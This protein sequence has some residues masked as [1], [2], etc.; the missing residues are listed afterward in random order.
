MKR[1]DSSRWRKLG[2]L[3]WPLI[4]VVSFFMATT[5]LY[6]LILAGRMAGLQLPVQGVTASLA[7]SVVTYGLT[8]GY[9]FF[10]AKLFKKRVTARDAGVQRPVSWQDIGLGLGGFVIYAATATALLE[11]AKLLLSPEMVNQP[12]NIGFTAAYGGERVLAFM[13]LVVVAPI[14]EEVIFRGILYGKLRQSALPRWASIGITSL[15]FALAHGQVNVGID[16]FVLSV[17]ACLLRDATG[18][19]WASVILHMMKN[20]LTFYALFVVRNMPMQ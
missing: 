3:T 16:V 4:L 15:L 17:M 13:V 11:A 5:S 7:I 1:D 8:L 14:V 12:Q 10:I 19:I 2:W 6:L 20:G 9:I 18:S